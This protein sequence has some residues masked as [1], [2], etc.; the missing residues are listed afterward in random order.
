M[1]DNNA[2]TQQNNNERPGQQPTGVKV[3]LVLFMQAIFYRKKESGYCT[4]PS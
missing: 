2:G 3:R 1:S 4:H